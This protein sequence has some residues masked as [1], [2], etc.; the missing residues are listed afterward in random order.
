MCT[1]KDIVMGNPLGTDE[2]GTLKAPAQSS[3]KLNT[4]VGS[5]SR[6]GNSRFP[7]ETSA[8]MDPYKLDGRFVEGALG[9]GKTKARG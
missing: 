3:S 7:I 2:S 4:S 5:G 6:P 8:P 9:T 1:K